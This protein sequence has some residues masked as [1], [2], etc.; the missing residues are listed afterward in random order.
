MITVITGLMRSGTSPL[1]Q[2]AHQMG[3]TMGTYQ[4]FPWHSEHAHFQWEDA[5]LS[6]PLA[7]F[8]V[9][10]G[11][12][13]APRRLIDSYV[14]IRQR[15]AK[16]KPWGVKTPFLLPFVEHLR[17]VCEEIDEKLTLVLTHREFSETITSIRRQLSHMSEFERGEV[18]PRV[19][20]IQDELKGHWGA[21]SKGAAIF[22]LENTLDHPREVAGKLA[23]LAGVKA[24]IDLAV[25]GIRGRDL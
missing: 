10:P 15:K 1:A 11:D 17:D 23:I 20:G 24:D 12:P 2:M 4:R 22:P 5:A 6:E 18:A 25:I 9:N 7:D 13:D 21:A 16:G 14:R 3:V 19:F 8:I